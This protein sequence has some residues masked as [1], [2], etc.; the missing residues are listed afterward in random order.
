MVNKTGLPSGLTANLLILVKN[1]MKQYKQPDYK[2]I[3]SDILTK[4][5]PERKK[6]FELLLQKQELSAL[7]IIDMNEK[8]FGNKI[9]S[10]KNQQLKSYSKED[11][12]Q[13]LDFQ[14]KYNFNNSDL[15]SYFKLSR[16]TVTKWK[17]LYGQ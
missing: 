14:K 1:V 16:N 15:A 5:Y 11:I 10:R 2:A 13:I 3:Y 4:M 6:E 9:S 17:K 12:L 8:I 7:D